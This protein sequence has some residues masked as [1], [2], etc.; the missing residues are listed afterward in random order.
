MEV[1]EELEQQIKVAVAEVLLRE[2]LFN[3]AQLILVVL[4]VKAL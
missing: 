4:A 2:Q 3:Q 1:Q